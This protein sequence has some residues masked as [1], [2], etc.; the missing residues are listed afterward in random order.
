MTVAV[1][2]L[3]FYLIRQNK[4]KDELLAAAG[5]DAADPNFV[6]AFEDKTDQENMNFRYIY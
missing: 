1:V 4:K 3:R 5:L 6:H 2:S